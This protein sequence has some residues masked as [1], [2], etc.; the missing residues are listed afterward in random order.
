MIE[1]DLIDD[2]QAEKK[3]GELKDRETVLR[4][5]LDQ[6]AATLAEV[7]E[8]ATV[9]KYVEQF[10]DGTIRVYDDDGFSYP[11]GNDLGSW[12]HLWTKKGTADHPKLVS[13]AFG[14]N[15]PDGKPVGVYITPA[16]GSRHGPKRFTYQV[17]GRLFMGVM[18]RALPLLSTP[19]NAPPFTLAGAIGDD[20]PATTKSIIP[21]SLRT[22]YAEVVA[23]AVELRQQGKTLAEVCEELNR[24]GYRTRTNKPWRHPQQLCKLLRSF[25]SEEVGE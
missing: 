5:E 6:L 15:L 23:K 8:A 20:H 10:A 3:L 11:G 1:K 14:G 12:M 16:G 13:S 9:R 22:V 7:P 21:Q 2:G 24:L 19:H 25:D 17:R 18:P 4:A